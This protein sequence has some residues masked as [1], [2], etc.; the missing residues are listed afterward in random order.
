MHQVGFKDS[1]I[2]EISTH[3]ETRHQGTAHDNLVTNG[4]TQLLVK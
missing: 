4:P 3:K 2:G 1:M